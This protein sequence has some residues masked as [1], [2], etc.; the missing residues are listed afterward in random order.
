VERGRRYRFTAWV[1]TRGVTGK[2]VYLRVKP[3]E[4]GVKELRSKR[5]T[6]DRDWTR[7]EIVFTPDEG[8]SF[9]V[10]GLVV[11]GPGKAWFDDLELTELE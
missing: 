5:L 4:D 7:M 2:G 8:Q 3:R 1:R 11:E 9:A 6:G 10:L